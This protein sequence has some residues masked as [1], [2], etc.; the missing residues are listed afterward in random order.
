MPRP[1]L[2]TATLLTLAIA[3]PLWGAG[4]A[5]KADMEIVRDAIR[6]NK[7]ALVSANVTLTDEEAARFWPVYDRYQ[8]QLAAV[9]DRFAKV[10]TDYAASFEDLSN[11]Q[12]LKLAKDYQTVEEDRLK[13]RRAYL[14]ALEKVLP[15]RKAVRVYQIENKIDAVVRYDLATEIPVVKE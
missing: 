14:A 15:G 1:G 11:E 10:L 3:A 13:V 12:A 9:N 8:K 7:K 2:L 4:E 6:A 5:T